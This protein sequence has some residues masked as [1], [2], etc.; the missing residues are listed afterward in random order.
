M[1]KF[2]ANYVISDSGKLLKNGI[3]LADANGMAINTIDTNGDLDEIAQLVFLN[4]ILFPN[5]TYFAVDLS[6]TEN[7]QEGSVAAFIASKVKAHQQLATQ[8]LVGILKQ[9]QAEFPELQIPE[10][11]DEAFAVLDSGFKKELQPGIFLATYIDL[12]GLKFRTETKLRRI[13]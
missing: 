11:L 3:L 13:I 4:G 10:L 2:A 5:Y 6:G 9:V 7:L 12:V 1:R 8:E